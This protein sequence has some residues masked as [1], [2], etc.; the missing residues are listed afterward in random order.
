MIAYHYICKNCDDDEPLK[1]LKT[2]IDDQEVNKAAKFA[3]KRIFE[4]LGFRFDQ[5]EP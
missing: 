2:A 3:V 4:T 5:K 1:N